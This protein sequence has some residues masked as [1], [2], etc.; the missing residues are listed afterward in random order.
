MS[1]SP[2]LSHIIKNSLNEKIPAVMQVTLNVTKQCVTSQLTLFYNF[3]YFSLVLI[4]LPEDGHA[5]G[6][7]YVGEWKK[8]VCH[9]FILF[10]VLSWFLNQL[11]A[12]PQIQTPQFRTATFIIKLEVLE[13]S[14]YPAVGK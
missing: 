5:A 13:H 2:D 8:L 3:N 9:R 14:N 11:Q 1:A 4:V 7:K 6:P 10:R 12:I